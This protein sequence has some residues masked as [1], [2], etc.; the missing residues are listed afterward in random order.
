MSGFSYPEWIGEIYPTGTK[1]KDML[2]AYTEIFD[3]VEINMTFR[4]RP[5]ENTMDLW[6]A[7]VP[8]T[9]RFSLK[10][11]AQI[12]HWRKLVDVAE[13]FRLFAEHT[14]RLGPTLGPI[15]F[16]VP[17]VVKFDQ[18]VFDTFCDEIAPDMAYAFEPRDP[19]FLTPDALA[20]LTR[21]R[22]PL[23]LN[24]DLF[25]PSL[26]TVTGPFAYFRFHRVGVY[27]KPELEARAELVKNLSEQMDVY[28][29]FSHEDNPESV[30]PALRFKKLIA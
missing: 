23:C 29:F 20:A 3:A 24:D 11:N 6:R 25:D 9:F 13:P 22:M 16:Q 30:K 28:V 17:E 12:T 21:R 1:Q 7:A 19:S 18:Q 15:L 8:D 2:R 4:R 26:Y 5:R 27:K 14:G 10:A